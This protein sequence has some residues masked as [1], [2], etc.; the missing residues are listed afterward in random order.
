MSLDIDFYLT[1]TTLKGESKQTIVG[2]FNWTH[3]LGDMAEAANIRQLLWLQRTK[4]DHAVYQAYQIYAELRPALQHMKENPEFYKQ[5]D[6]ENG[7]GI[8]DD[9]IPILDDLLK[10][11][12]DYPTAN[13]R[14]SL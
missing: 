2:E 4:Y 3:N 13:V 8:Y 5:F 1:T 7:W 11:C 14:V 6:S 9:F 12:E 10:V